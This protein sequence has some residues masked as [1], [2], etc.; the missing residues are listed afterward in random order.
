[1]ERDNLMHGARAALNRD[2]E[3]RAWAEQYIKELIR[4]EHKEL[5]DEEFETYWKYH[6]PEIMHERASEALAAFKS[7]KI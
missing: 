3:K 1:M 6:K 2:P 7:R 4:P 5:S